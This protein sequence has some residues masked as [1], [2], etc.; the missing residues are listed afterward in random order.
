M[1][2][3]KHFAWNSLFFLQCISEWTCKFLASRILILNLEVLPNLT[4]LKCRKEAMSS[5]KALQDSLP[6]C[7][8]VQCYSPLFSAW[9]HMLVQPHR[10]LV[11]CMV[12]SSP[13]MTGRETDPR[14]AAPHNQTPGKRWG[15]EDIRKCHRLF[16]GAFT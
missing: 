11:S 1:D 12:Q 10:R 4:Y 14:P 9:R 15:N 7:E 3:K 13:P 8:T 2:K 16:I 5:R 6:M